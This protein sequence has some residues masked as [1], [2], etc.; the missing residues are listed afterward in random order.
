M[1]LVAAF[2][3]TSECRQEERHRTRGDEC[4]VPA[5]EHVIEEEEEALLDLLFAVLQVMLVQLAL[6]DVLSM[7]LHQL[8]IRHLVAVN[9]RESTSVSQRLAG[10]ANI[11]VVHLD[12][13][14]WVAVVVVR[15]PSWQHSR[16]L[17]CW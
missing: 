17:V 16:S 6:L 9:A 7:R 5:H 14:T 3:R 15:R 4:T 11:T 13:R 8:Q 12:A 10:H 2:E 1:L